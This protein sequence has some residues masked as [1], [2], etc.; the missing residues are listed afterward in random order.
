MHSSAHPGG[1]IMSEQAPPSPPKRRWFRIVRILGIFAILLVALILAA[2]WI[3]AKTGLRDRAING[4][5]ASPSVT[6]SSESAS[7]GWFSPLSIHGMQLKS[8]N[9]RIDVRVEDIATEGSPWQLWESSP[10]L[11]TIRVEKPHITLELPLDV[12]LERA[13]RLELEPTFTAVVKDAALTVRVPDL[14]DAAIDVD[15]I[16]MT[17]RVEKAEGGRVLT[18]DPVVVFD[19][20]KLS[21]K[22]ADK[23]LHLI[24]PS[25]GEFPDL[26]GEISLSLDKLRVP[27]GI[28]KDELATRVEVEGK[29][30]FH[31]VSSAV[32]SPLR[33]ALVHL[34]AHMNGKHESEVLRVVQ[35]GEA[36]FQ[37][38]E[39]R[40]HHEGLRISVP[41]I[42]PG[43]QVSS[44][45]SVGL[46][47][48]LDLHVELPHLDPVER[49]ERSPAKCQVTG[50]IGSPKIAVQ[51][52]S[53]VLR[54]PQHTEP[55]I[56]AHG[57]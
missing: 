53:L 27:L 37:V 34:V 15:A 35:D 6:A 5:L 29:L 39:G 8:T 2:P 49:K 57:I 28:P 50:T 38:R 13:Q 14:D 12:K 1:N 42:D 17:F 43:L 24:D 31:Q 45:G 11:G 26:G 47:R 55:I 32:K 40:L 48:T 9:N 51:N 4:I 3:V 41:D 7:F 56:A 46:D 25:L 22:L 19:R 23:C 54:P 16:N 44:W 20:R 21:P 10:D 18:L 33:Q 30:S 36:R 52:A